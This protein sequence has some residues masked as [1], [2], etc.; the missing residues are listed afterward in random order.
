[1]ARGFAIVDACVPFV[2]FPIS[3]WRGASPIGVACGLAL[4]A[5]SLTV[6][7]LCAHRLAM[8]AAH[9]TYLGA[10]RFIAWNMLAEWPV[11]GLASLLTNRLRGDAI[12]A[13]VLCSWLWPP[14]IAGLLVIDLG[15]L[16][17]ELGRTWELAPLDTWITRRE[18]L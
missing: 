7:A 2:A 14:V 11:L 12:A 8:R 1:L 3:I 17:T 13:L 10:F 18:S 6:V 9:R 5:A 15:R 4:T 16:R